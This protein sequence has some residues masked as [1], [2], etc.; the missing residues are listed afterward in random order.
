MKK[1]ELKEAV[2]FQATSFLPIPFEEAAMDIFPLREFEDEQGKK[3]E[4][5]FVAVRRQQV[6]NLELLCRI[7]GLKLAAVEIEPLAIL[8]LNRFKKGGIKAFLSMGAS[9]SCFFV[10]QDEILLFYRT[11]PFACT[12]FYHSADLIGG[13]NYSDTAVTE[14]G[15]D[16]KYEY[17]LR[18]L[19]VEL[20][21]S[22]EYYNMQYPGISLESII[23]YGGG[24]RLG[25]LYGIL[26]GALGY[27]VESLEAFSNIV[28]PEKL[29]ETA[30]EELKYD[31]PL[32]LGLAARNLI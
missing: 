30:I 2:L 22:I 26:E 1:Q 21:R 12:P 11:L 3:T 4:V 19:V 16:R 13:D 5:F 23:V 14:A 31:F 25:S 6:E 8:R 28:F 7:A 20:N 32:A 29:S 17:I 27:K 10:F 24:T 15:Q 18:D 9:R